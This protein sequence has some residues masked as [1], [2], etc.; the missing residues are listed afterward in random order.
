MAIFFILHKCLIFYSYCDIIILY[1]IG[2]LFMARYKV[3]TEVFSVYAGAVTHLLKFAY[4]L[5]IIKKM[6][7]IINKFKCCNFPCSSLA[8]FFSAVASIFLSCIY[9]TSQCIYITTLAGA[10]FHYI[11]LFI[12]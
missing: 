4:L 10:V 12:S 9:I 5:Y 1:L 11:L 3:Y 7:Y 2:L 8:S 6:P